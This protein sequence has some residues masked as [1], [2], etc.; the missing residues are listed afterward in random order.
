MTNNIPIEATTS[1]TDETGEAATTSH[2]TETGKEQPATQVMKKGVTCERLL[3]AAM[4]LFAERGFEATSTKLIAQQAG[5]PHGLI[6]Y[7]FGTKHNILASL[8]IK[9]SFLAEIEA[10]FADARANGSTDPRSTLVE[11]CMKCFESYQRHRPLAHIM[12]QESHLD[13]QVRMTLQQF[14]DRIIT[15]I[16]EF[17]EEASGQ[18]AFRPLD[19]EMVAQALLF[20]LAKNM[21]YR[22][23]PEPHAFCERL[24]DA[25]VSPRA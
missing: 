3:D 4:E 17:L 20:T 6:H 15:L 9:R 1:H 18:G 19:A 10:H 11:C 12:E 23:I 8:L 13:Q 24:V 7:Y 14:E 22:G 21:R 5:V 16:A 2:A 25:L